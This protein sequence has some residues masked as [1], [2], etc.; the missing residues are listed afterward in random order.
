M[1]SRTWFQALHI[2]FRRVTVTANSHEDR[3]CTQVVGHSVPEQRFISACAYGHNGHNRCSH[4][5]TIQLSTSP[6][7][8][9]HSRHNDP[10][11]AQR[12]CTGT[13]RSG[14]SCSSDIPPAWNIRLSIDPRRWMRHMLCPSRIE[15][16]EVLMSMHRQTEQ[17]SA[18]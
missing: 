8:Y 10:T 6:T 14:M 3:Q 7:P 15:F 2:N 17:S 16:S 9:P 13:S 18:L 5:R 1:S 11:S 12:Q 4:T